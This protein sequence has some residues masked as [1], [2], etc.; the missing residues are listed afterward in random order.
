MEKRERRDEDTVTLEDRAHLYALKLACMS[1]GLWADGA[2][3][4]YDPGPN[5]SISEWYGITL[6]GSPDDLSM[7]IDREGG[8]Y[9]LWGYDDVGDPVL[10][11]KGPTIQDVTKRWAWV[12]DKE[13]QC[14]VIEFPAIR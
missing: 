10:L 13:T 6:P 14:K 9:R 3:Y 11:A 1:E 2:L 12:L 7:Y 5:D 8:V 4:T